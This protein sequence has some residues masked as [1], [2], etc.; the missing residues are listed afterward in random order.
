MKIRLIAAGTKMP[1]WV[2]AGVKEYSRR[3][4]RDFQLS[5]TEIP[6]GARGKSADVQRAIRKEGE[7][8]LAALTRNDYTVALDVQGRALSTEALADR[9]EQI[10]E[11]GQDLALLVGGPDGLAA[12]CL[13]QSREKWSLSALTLP[14]PVVRVVVAEQIY[15][16]WSFLN[17]HPYHRA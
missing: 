13:Q 4:P 8:M 14:H 3:L 9:V 1:A 15:R 12:E 10:R 11:Q 17:G 5:I 2:E 7:A 16:A 6:L